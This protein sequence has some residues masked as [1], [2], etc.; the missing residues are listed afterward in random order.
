MSKLDE[1][2]QLVFLIYD[3]GP[4]FECWPIVL[5]Q[6]ADVL[7]GSSA[8]FRRASANN[9]QDVSAWFRVD[10]TLQQLYVER[11]PR[12]TMSGSRPRS[13][14]GVEFRTTAKGHEER[15]PPARLNGRYPLSEPTFAG[16]SGNGKDAP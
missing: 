12:L 2:S 4:D 3:A 10:Q 13:R 14:L 15:F 11:N 6:L 16:A 1:Y 9:T 8:L 7:Q 5:W